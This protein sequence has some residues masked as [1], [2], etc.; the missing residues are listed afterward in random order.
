MVTSSKGNSFRVTGTLWWEFASHRWIPLTQCFLWSAWTNDWVNNWG[1]GDW[2]RHRAHY[3]VTVMPTKA[4]A[5]FE[6]LLLYYHLLHAKPFAENRELFWYQLV[7][8]CRYRRFITTTAVADKVGIVT[9]I[10]F[11]C[12]LEVQH[13]NIWLKWPM[14]CFKY[15][16]MNGNN[17]ILIPISLKFVPSGSI[18]N[19]SAF[20]PVVAC[21]F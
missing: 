8:D 9:N 13:I 16:S 18:V 21:L 1:A 3:D 17:C 2:G 10:N 7:R 20:V 15:I 6:F 5:S 4:L 12:R 11:L 14:F 19:M